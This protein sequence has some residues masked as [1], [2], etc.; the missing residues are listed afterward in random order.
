[1]RWVA[2][3]VC[4]VAVLGTV[5]CGGSNAQQGYLAQGSDWVAFLQVTRNGN[6]LSGNLEDAS[7][8]PSDPTKVSS[9]NASFTGATDGNSIT[10]TFQE[11]LGFATSMSG[12]YSGS[13][14]N[15][16]IPQTDGTLV[17]ARFSPS[18]TDTYNSAVQ[19][20]QQKAQQASA[21]QQAQQAAQQQ[22]QLEADERASVDKAV[23]SVNNDLKG[24]INDIDSLA[25][26]LNAAIPR[27]KQQA[28]N[29]TVITYNDM[30][31]V[32]AEG[33]ASLTCAADAG[34]VAADAGTVEG[35]LGTINGDGGTERAGVQRITSDLNQLDADFQKLGSA[36]A[37][38]PSY[39]PSGVPT[40]AQVSQA[41]SEAS[42]DT[43]ADDA[44]V[45]GAVKQVQDWLNQANQYVAAANTV[46]G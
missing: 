1:M 46:C 35:D 17:T 4:V 31:R 39:Q 45:G 44:F 36:Q 22:A 3:V 11:G 41:H 26:T 34:I 15:L 42:K 43:S 20:L 12:S 37:A 13:D 8:S 18:N 29:D 10:L 24:V 5:A 21:D 7:I 16:S 9:V 2:G 28:Y 19:A 14:I 38:I 27:D 33:R 23:A 25:N 32:Q 6:S 40:S 30:K